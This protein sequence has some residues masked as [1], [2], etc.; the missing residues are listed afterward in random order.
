MIRLSSFSIAKMSLGMGRAPAPPR[1]S[2][3]NAATGEPL[4]PQFH[5]GGS[6]SS[7]SQVPESSSKPIIYLIAPSEG[8]GSSYVIRSEKSVD[9]M[10]SDYIQKVHDKNRSYLEETS[11]HPPFILPPPPRVLE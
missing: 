8:A 7:R 3:P 9:G 1:N 2:A 6:S 4:L 10:A 5:G 11:S